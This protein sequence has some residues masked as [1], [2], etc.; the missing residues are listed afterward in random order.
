MALSFE[1]LCVTMHQTD[2]SKIQ[3]MN[4]HSNVVF[5]NQADETS[6][7]EIRFEGHCAKMVTTETRGVGKNRNVALLNA[8]A[9]ICLLADD[10]VV[11]YENLEEKVVG[12]FEK[13]PDADVIVFNLET[14]DK[15]RKQ[16]IYSKTKKCS[17]FCR[18]PWG[19]FR[20]AFR[21]SSWKKANVWFTTLFGGGCIFPS[22]EDSM[23][24]NGM[25]ENGMCFYVSKE[26]IGNISFAESTW[27][28]GYDEKF[29]YGK[30]AY[31]KNAHPKSFFFWMLYFS[32]RTRKMS[33][34]GF[35]KKMN[36]MYKGLG[37]YNKLLSCEEYLRQKN[38]G[39]GNE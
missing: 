22:G 7:K 12:E 13:H 16:R 26:V 28:T 30:G 4:I 18:M 6:L 5:A 23:W 8:S 35:W 37:G 33:Q 15:K 25:K 21:S 29:F 3:S 24:L 10:D 1:I 27:F 34:M 32:L 39:V 38:N 31:Y 14:D 17:K 2:F 20:I 36:W 9:D 19:A 11:Y